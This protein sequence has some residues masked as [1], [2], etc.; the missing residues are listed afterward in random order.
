MDEIRLA[1]RRDVDAELAR[2]ITELASAQHNRRA[3]T[4][5]RLR[6]QIV[7]ML[8]VQ[9]FSVGDI[10]PAAGRGRRRTTEANG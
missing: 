2:I 3:D 1:L 4:R 6:R 9:G 10:F 7:A 8:A 5:R